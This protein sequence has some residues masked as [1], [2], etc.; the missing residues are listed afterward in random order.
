MSLIIQ[1]SD[2]F[3]ADMVKQ[4]DWYRDK[5]GPAVATQYVNAVEATL[6]RL[7]KMPGLGRP[8]FNNWPE[9]AGMRSYC[10]QRPYQRHLIFYRFDDN[11]LYAER[12]IQGSRDLPRR[13]LQSP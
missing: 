10:A 4:V 11:M 8:R 9:L 2:D 5:A 3:W 1:Q 6:L 7:A 13:L 12:V